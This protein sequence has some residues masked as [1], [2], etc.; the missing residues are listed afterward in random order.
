MAD[1][2]EAPAVPTAAPTAPTVAVETP[3]VAVH[4]LA[5]NPVAT[6]PEAAHPE[7]APSSASPAEP[8]LLSETSNIA[9]HPPVV[10]TAPFDPTAQASTSNP[11][12]SE[13][14]SHPGSTIEVD[15]FAGD[16]ALGED[17]DARST[18]SAS[19]TSSIMAFREENGRRYHSYKDGAYFFP[20]DETEN[21]RLDMQH[22]VFLKSTGGRLSLAPISEDVQN[23]IDIGTG[24]GIWAIDFADEYP[25][26]RVIGTDLSPIQPAW[27][28]PNLSFLIDDC[29]DEWIYDVKFDLIHA[30]MMCG[31]L[32]TA[33]WSTF[34]Q[35]AYKNLQPG[36]WLELQDINMPF[37][38]DDDSFRPEHA[39]WKWSDTLLEAGAK[40][41]R[42]VNVASQCKKWMEEAGFVD[43]REDVH[44]WPQN[45]WA[46]DPRLKEIGLWTM[47][48]FLQGIHGLSM[49]P[50]TRGLGMS[51]EEVEVFL[52]D[53]RK[54]IRN[55][56]IRAY[57]TIYFVYGRKPEN[58]V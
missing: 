40:L 34:F 22:A 36:G 48:N 14:T 10:D 2:Q 11:D 5:A 31:S 26:A 16:S 17:E 56:N 12:E 51:K 9:T 1:Q 45:Q 32:T 53:V 35:E 47:T 41:D 19:I 54:D 30:R 57:W 18:L 28:P 43:V 21:D 7:A 20:N 46:K 6:R 3:H 33:G 15:D 29:A 52:A 27:V 44:K 4:P 13:N 58:A 39:L 24:T 38:G 55:V 49:A 8:A 25:S 23:V 50:F 42:P 37:R